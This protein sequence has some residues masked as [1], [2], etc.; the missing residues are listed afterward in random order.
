MAE[1]VHDGSRILPY[2][3]RL[4]RQEDIPQ[5]N[6]IDREAFSTQWP[7]PNYRHELENQLA[8]YIVAYDKDRTTEEPEP[9]MEAAL[10]R[11]I[12]GIGHWF[13]RDHSPRQSPPPRLRQYITGFAGIW[14]L[15]DE[16]HITNIAVRKS[17]QRQGI[18]ELLMI[19]V[20]GMAREMKA[21][22]VTLEVRVSNTT[23]QNLYIKYGFTQVGLRR[24]Y[25][26]D[27]REDAVLMSTPSINSD[28]FQARLQQLQ[29]A[30]LGDEYASAK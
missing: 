20:I 26:T 30:L 9:R 23:A 14:V 24:G 13:N 4:M 19:N 22:T 10:N 17:H 21:D 25:Y 12:Y 27:N 15:A 5:V 3:V 2:R 6:E 11:L 28:S 8:R 18:G 29:Q 1:V 7:P 16:A